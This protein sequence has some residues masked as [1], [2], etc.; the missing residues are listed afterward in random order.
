M[1]E[2]LFKST[3]YQNHYI[4]IKPYVKKYIDQWKH[5]NVKKNENA[6]LYTRYV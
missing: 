6:V 2:I 1:Q 3:D 5:M 4:K